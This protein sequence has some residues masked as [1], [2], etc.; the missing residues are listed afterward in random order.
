M[1]ES[2]QVCVCVCVCAHGCVCNKCVNLVQVMK[3][4]TSTGLL[5]PMSSAEVAPLHC[6]RRSRTPTAPGIRS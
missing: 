2:V 6:R 3:K 1:Y 4:Y 5:S